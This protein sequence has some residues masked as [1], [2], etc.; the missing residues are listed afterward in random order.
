[1]IG[2]LG[3]CDCSMI[4]DLGICDC[5]VIGDPGDWRLTLLLGESLLANCCQRL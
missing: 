5:L 2:D 3:I 4:A 1:M